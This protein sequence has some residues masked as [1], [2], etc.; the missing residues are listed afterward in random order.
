MVSTIGLFLLSFSSTIGFAV[1]L[2]IKF[3]S[4]SPNYGELINKNNI[5]LS[6]FPLKKRR[7]TPTLPT[8]T[9]ARCYSM[10]PKIWGS[11]YIYWL[12]VDCNFLQRKLLFW[13][14]VHFYDLC[15]HRLSLAFACAEATLKLFIQRTFFNLNANIINKKT[16]VKFFFNFFCF[17]FL[18]V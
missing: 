5:Y 13:D 1:F 8:F 14:R 12:S 2:S 15:I 10:F 18:T 11:S 9:S 17:Y 6:V 16:K 4:F 7:V 3:I